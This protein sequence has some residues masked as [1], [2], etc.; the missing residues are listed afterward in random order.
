MCGE[1]GGWTTYILREVKQ[2]KPLKRNYSDLS[3]DNQHRICF[4]VFSRRVFF[5]KGMESSKEKLKQ[6]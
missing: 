5:H 1:G 4:G 3:Y 6:M 2:E